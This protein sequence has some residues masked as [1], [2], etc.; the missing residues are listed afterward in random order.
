MPLKFDLLNETFECPVCGHP[1]LISVTTCEKC[2]TIFPDKKPLGGNMEL[3][4]EVTE[5]KEKKNVRKLIRSLPEKYRKEEK[6]KTR[7]EVIRDFQMVP[8]ITKEV[9]EKLYDV[10]GIKSLSELIW[11]MLSN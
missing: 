2:K 11:F 7:D 3:S 9:A 1:N 5:T 4:V 10:S 8:G 6:P